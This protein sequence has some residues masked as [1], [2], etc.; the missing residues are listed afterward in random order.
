V[1]APRPPDPLSKA[2][3]RSLE[4]LLM[5]ENKGKQRDIKVQSV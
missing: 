4:K 1:R 2:A 5:A 3:G